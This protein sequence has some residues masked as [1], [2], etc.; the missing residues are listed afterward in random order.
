M[1]KGHAYADI[2]LESLNKWIDAYVDK[3]MKIIG[4]RIEKYLAKFQKEDEK[5][6]S[7]VDSG[8]KSKKEYEMWRK[9]HIASG[10]EWGKLVK[11]VG[12]QCSD[13]ESK[14]VDEI[15]SRMV[16]VYTENYN[17]AIREIRIGFKEFLNG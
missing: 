16:G 4:A 11:W 14:I 17:S 1:D 2:E 12:R 10:R 6:R 15:N 3:R 13:I 5:W 9:Q 8:L 7:D